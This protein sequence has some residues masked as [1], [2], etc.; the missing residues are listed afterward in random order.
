[1]VPASRSPSDLRP[2]WPSIFPKSEHSPQARS[3]AH[4]WLTG[5]VWRKSRKGT[6]HRRYFHADGR[7]VTVAFHGTNTT[8]VP[9]TLKSMVEEQAKWTENDLV[10]LGLLKR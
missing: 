4:F 2:S 10:R 7:R 8:F 5:F 1:M 6:G 3:S 9:K